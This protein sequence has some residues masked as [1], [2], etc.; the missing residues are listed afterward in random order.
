MSEARSPLCGQ[1]GALLTAPVLRLLDLL[2][3]D[4]GEARVV[5]GAVRDALLGL[6][7]ADIDIATTLL[8]DE[9]MRR[10]AAADIRAIPTG[11]EH[12]TVTLILEHRAYEVTT[13]RRDVTTDGRRATVAFGTDWEEDARRRDFTMNALSVDRAGVVH[14]PTGG[15]VDLMARRVRFI[16]EARAR[17]R[18][19]YLRILRFFRFHARYGNDPAD[20]H[21]LSAIVSERAGLS[22]LSGERVRAEM[23]KLLVAPRAAETVA[24]MADLGLFAFILGGVPRRLRLAR[25]CALETAPDA[26]LRLGALAVAVR[27]DAERLSVRLRLSRQERARLRGMADGPFSPQPSWPEQMQRAALYH[28]GTDVFRDRVLLAWASAGAAAD[29]ADWVRLMALPERWPVPHLPWSGRDVLAAGVAPGES[30]GQVLQDL[31][32]RW[33]AADFPSDEAVLAALFDAVV[34]SGRGRGTD[35]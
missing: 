22:G 8:P 24:L 10:A 33:I 1:A 4:G 19:D 20:P 15:C 2:S 14:D 21:A 30:V 32:R 7:V 13:L 29:A 3:Q 23:L 5:G 9:V 27:E 28:L 6:T 12:G 31:E 16:G 11:V 17:I 26:L 25:V 35:I 34:P 18:E